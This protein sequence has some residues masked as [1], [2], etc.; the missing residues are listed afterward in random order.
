MRIVIA[1]DHHLYRRGMLTVMGVESDI[2]VVAE[3]GSLPEAVTKCVELDPDVVILGHRPPR[4]SGIDACRAIRDKAPRTKILI[5]TGTGD[6]ADVVAAMAAGASGYLLKEFP[7]QQII[8][9]LRLAHR[10]QALIPLR[11]TSQL[12]RE[13]SRPRPVPPVESTAPRL[14]ER[15]LGILRLVGEGKANKE[16]AAQL[17]ISQNTV[18]NH[19]HNIRTKLNVGSRIELA[20]HGVAQGVDRLA[21]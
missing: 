9:S 5:L 18:K 6:E 19:I 2:D 14:S 20:M 3:V 4:H 8:E 1:D 21:P 13:L 15:E 12:I 16:I 17:Y 10:G 7:A 11:M